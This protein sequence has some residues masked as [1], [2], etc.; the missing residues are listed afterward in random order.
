[1]KIIISPAKKMKQD[2]DS[3]EC[4]ELPQLLH[5]TEQLYQ[6]LCRMSY[7]ELKRLWCCN[8][9]IAT[10]NYERLQKNGFTSESNTCNYVL[11]RNS[12]S[13]YGTLCTYG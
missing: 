1:M 5:Q 11:R 6:Q 12:V 4:H 13:L 8:D 9:Q 3:F 10:L 2:A 7:T